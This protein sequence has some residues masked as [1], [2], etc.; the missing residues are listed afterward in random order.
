MADEEDSPMNQHWI[1]FRFQSISNRINI[2]KSLIYKQL[3]NN[4][5]PELTEFFFN[6]K[7]QSS[8][9]CAVKMISSKL[10]TINTAEEDII[11]MLLLMPLYLTHH[12]HHPCPLAHVIVWSLHFYLHLFIEM[13]KWLAQEYSSVTSSINSKLAACLLMCQL[14]TDCA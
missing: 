6:Y 5:S 12:Q 7:V 4:S 11:T 9:R 10:T 3:T 14:W 8:N 1:D 13:L 2:C